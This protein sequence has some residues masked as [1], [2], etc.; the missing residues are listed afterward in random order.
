MVIP[1]TAWKLS[2]YIDM[3]RTKI[4]GNLERSQAFEETYYRNIPVLA[5]PP[6]FVGSKKQVH[7]EYTF[8][9]N[10]RWFQPDSGQPVPY[11]INPDP[12]PSGI[13][14]DPNDIA[15][16]A[17]AWTGVAGCSLTLS[18][19]GISLVATRRPAL[20]NKLRLQ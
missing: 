19:A 7:P 14:P 15:A 10:V 6:G 16:A 11:T 2:S 4:A 5:S 12:G 17:G 1:P 18:Y 9:G 20:P 13:A 8:L 3:V